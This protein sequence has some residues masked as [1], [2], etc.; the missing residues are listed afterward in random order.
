[1]IRLILQNVPQ[2]LPAS[3]AN[4]AITRGCVWKLELEHKEKEES[5]HP[6]LPGNW[7]FA[8]ER[9]RAYNRG[10]GGHVSLSLLS[11]LSACVAP[12][13]PAVQ[14]LQ[15]EGPRPSW[16]SDTVAVCSENLSK[17]PGVFP[18]GLEGA[19]NKSGC[20]GVR[21]ALLW[22]RAPVPK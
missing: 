1:M 4:A 13:L 9:R 8:C 2:L 5:R 11:H 20:L 12:I 18:E 22:P 3:V 15:D 16:H 14:C 19:G 17:R 10:R 21:V 7:S 6:G